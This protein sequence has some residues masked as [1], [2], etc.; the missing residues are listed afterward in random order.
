MARIQKTK[1][2]RLH[3]KHANPHPNRRK[4]NNQP[5]RIQQQTQIRSHRT[6]STHIVQLNKSL[7]YGRNHILD[8][9]SKTL[10]ETF[11]KIYKLTC[12]LHR[13]PESFRPTI[14]KEKL[15]PRSLD[16]KPSPFFQRFLGCQH[17]QSITLKKKSLN[18]I[19]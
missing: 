4:K 3:T 8:K 2:R 16:E 7:H 6:R 17:A 10:P 5:R 1:A 14:K 15:P 13:Y 19:H 18:R 12:G 11:D 9:M